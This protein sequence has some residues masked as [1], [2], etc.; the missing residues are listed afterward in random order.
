MFLQCCNN[1]PLVHISA[2][3]VNKLGHMFMEV[4]ML[5]HFPQPFHCAKAFREDDSADKEF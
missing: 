5:Q 3:I 4:R 2:R 1:Y